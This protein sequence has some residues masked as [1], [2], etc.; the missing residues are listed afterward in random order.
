VRR[1]KKENE[2]RHLTETY[3]SGLMRI[4]SVS[5]AL[6]VAILIMATAG[7][8][9]GHP[10][11]DEVEPGFV[12][13]STLV[14][15]LL[16][17]LG[18]S[19]FLYGTNP[20]RYW[21]R[22]I[23]GAVGSLV[24]VVTGLKILQWVDP[25]AMNFQMLVFPNFL[26]TVLSS[27]VQMSL[28]T[29]CVL[30]GGGLAGVLVAW[31]SKRTSR[32]IVALFGIGTVCCGVVMTIG[33]IY[34]VPFLYGSPIKPVS[35]IAAI[36]FMFLGIEIWA[37]AGSN[38]WPNSRFVGDSPYARL[39][40]GFLPAMLVLLFLISLPAGLL[41]RSMS[42][43]VTALEL[44]A[45]VVV[46]VVAVSGL[47]HRIGSEI[48]AYN[49]ELRR[50]DTKLRESEQK[51]RHM[52]ERSVDAV[53]TVNSQGIITYMSPAVERIF[54][55]KPEEMIGK[56]IKNFHPESELP[57]LN[58]VFTDALEAGHIEGA[59]LE[60][61]RKDG[62]H[63]YIEVN[64]SATYLDGKAVEVQ[65]ILRDLTE[66]RRVEDRLRES[67]ERAR[68]LFDRVL[69]GVYKSTH[70]GRFV[71]V[72]PAFVKM[73]GYSSKQEMLDIPDIKK[74]LYFSAEERGKHLLDTNQEE[75]KEY[76]MR[77]KDGSEIWVEDHGH[78]IHDEKGDVIFHEG[79]LRDI[80]E[81]KRMED[82]LQRYSAHL[83]ELVEERTKKLTESEA[84]FR[85]LANELRASRERLEYIITSNP[86]LIIISK[87][88][89]DYS[90]YYAVYQS[91]STL[92]MTGFDSDEFIG[93]KGSAFWATRVHP[94][95]LASFK[96]G[97]VKFWEDGHRVC[98]F[99]FLHKNGTYH[100][101]HEEAQLIRDA[102]GRPDEVMAYWTDV[103]E[104][105]ELALRLSEA[106]HLAGVGQAAAMVGHDLRNP[107][108]VIAGAVYLLRTQQLEPRERDEILES[109]QKS[110]DYSDGIVND[111]LD[112][113]RTFHLTHVKTTPKRLVARALERIQV[114]PRIM[115]HDQT[116]EQPIIA[117]DQDR[118]K[119]VLVNLIEN[120]VDAMPMGGTLTLSSETLDGHAQLRISDTG[121]GLPKDILQ[122]LWK[123]LQTTK[124][125]GMGLGLA[126]CKR[127]IDA[128]EGKISVESKQGEGTTF[129]IR[130]PI[131]A[132][133]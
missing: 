87:P 90:D 89:P 97:T 93:E 32:T 18:V 19:W 78:Y 40:R 102:N 128:H 36:A 21:P 8:A 70:E 45:G 51:F 131:K 73:F 132:T 133:T 100:W 119:R 33:Y 116:G 44:L 124:A 86:A 55:Y 99:R 4:I 27:N 83:E 38:C 122:N 54:R 130:L 106:Q 110:V 46:A 105:K 96:E 29:A 84:E 69:D 15:T 121:A 129:T 95:D 76:R 74:E 61:L 47:S 3:E 118:M 60:T 35:L 9:T 81:R 14:I 82:E 68:S 63:G 107:L 34:Q 59:L 20:G 22:I 7:L 77:R 113:A 1:E 71:D 56:P 11:L 6:I 43:I 50:A 26:S 98:E 104:L 75:M 111:L 58:K 126:I 53:A 16:F 62:S 80:T 123:P 57:R 31:S 117:V 49:A 101:I 112:Y 10:L 115:V 25:T 127:I 28:V 72:N 13:I 24:T 17:L 37:A 64:A 103:T 39:L 66:R 23:V 79:I 92:A 12:P 108:Q 41:G 42:P 114:P 65:S 67:E 52:A 94:D 30:F 125:K 5:A 2:V 91:R 85:E 120:A 109:I 48:D 88:F